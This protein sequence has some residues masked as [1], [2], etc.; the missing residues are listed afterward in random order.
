[1][2]PLNHPIVDCFKQQSDSKNKVEDIKH[3][4]KNMHSL[5]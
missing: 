1:M 4:M 3:E 5:F 2:R